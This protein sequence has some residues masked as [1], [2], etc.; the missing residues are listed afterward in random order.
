M[1]TT[2]YFPL[3]CAALAGWLVAV[4]AQAMPFPPRDPQLTVPVTQV[5]EECPPGYTLHPR[6]NL[7]VAQPTCP[8]GST[9][10]PRLHLCVTAPTC[11]SGSTWHP[12]LHRCITP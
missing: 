5:A 12:K 11:P 4:S 7:C 8:P 10:H 2:S 9:L 1:F 3:A 6:L